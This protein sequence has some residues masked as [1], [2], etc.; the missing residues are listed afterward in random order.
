MKMK[1]TINVILAA[2]LG[3]GMVFPSG[4]DKEQGNVGGE[5]ASS[6]CT[7]HS[8][9]HWDVVTP[10]T[11]TVEGQAK[12]TCGVCYTEQFKSLPLDPEAHTYGEWAITQPNA[13]TDGVAVKTCEGNAEHKYS[14]TLPKTSDERYYN[15]DTLSSTSDGLIAEITKRPSVFE[16]GIRTYT[17][18]S[19][20]GTIAF[21]EEIDA[22]GIV[23]IRDAVEL[24]VGE[25]VRDALYRADGDRGYNYYL[26][27]SNE[28]FDEDGNPLP[29]AQ[30]ASVLNTAKNGSFASAPSTDV[31]SEGKTSDKFTLGTVSAKGS[32]YISGR[33]LQ[34][35]LTQGNTA[36]EAI[37]FQIY[38][39]DD[40]AHKY[41]LFT[42][43]DEEDRVD[44][45]TYEGELSPNAW[46]SITLT[47]TMIDGAR[48][49][50]GSA[51][52]TGNYGVD[53]CIENT[54][55]VAGST[56]EAK[57]FYVDAFQSMLPASNS[58]E[59]YLF[60]DGYTYI[61]DE[62]NNM[63]RWYFFDEEENLYGLKQ[64]MYD[65]AVSEPPII[66]NDLLQGDGSEKFLNGSRL[67]LNWVQGVSTYFGLEALLQG[68]YNLARANVN[69]DYQEEITEIN[70]KK[71]YSFSFGVVE[72]S[73]EN[74]GY[75]SKIA[76]KFTLS[77]LF[78]IETLE[79]T[80]N[81]YVNNTAQED[82]NNILTWDIDETT[83]NAYVVPG[84]EC[85]TRYVSYLKMAQQLKPD[86]GVT[87]TNPH[88]LEEMFIQSFE[89]TYRD[90]ELPALINLALNK[91]SDPDFK[92]GNISPKSAL[93]KYAFDA[94]SYYVRIP[95]EPEDIPIDFE[96]SQWVA[97]CDS[98]TKPG[99]FFL[100]PHISGEFDIV[101]KTTRGI[102]EVIHCSV[103]SNPP[104]LLCPTWF[105]YENGEYKKYTETDSTIVNGNMPI[106]IK[107]VMVGQP[108]YFTA[109]VPEAE[110]WTAASSYLV[111]IRKN[112]VDIYNTE[113]VNKT[114]ENGN[115]YLDYAKPCEYAINTYFMGI[116][117]V[118]YY[119]QE[120]GTHNLILT[121]TESST[122]LCK[123]RVNV[124]AAPSMAE[125]TAKEYEGT[126]RFGSTPVEVAFSDFKELHQIVYQKD[127]VT[128][129][130]LLDE[131]GEK[132]PEYVKA[133]SIRQDQ[134]EEGYLLVDGKRVPVTE[135]LGYEMFVTVTEGGEGGNYEVLKVTNHAKDNT[136]ETE[137]V[138]GQELLYKLGLN[139]AY[140]F[141]LSKTY[142]EFDNMSIDVVLS[143]KVA[144]EGSGGEEAGGAGGT[145]EP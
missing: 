96:S 9:G 120:I 20:E 110:K 34:S 103:K 137:H 74:S 3:I 6:A 50:A 49:S 17:V 132:I 123:M 60:G 10:S 113:M 22:T 100:N 47:K 62:E 145:V 69:G 117:V 39:A 23:N 85:G 56:N 58:E 27:L 12:G 87:D 46:T 97:V 89:V 93:D 67:Y 129:E 128:G 122:I 86:A 44:G 54:Q 65:A 106:T 33:M 32:F 55:F 28:K 14:V 127:A 81:V 64:E 59:H 76:V 83:R 115:T 88:K 35:G 133:T 53:V 135:F 75:F 16:T 126:L 51:Y 130:Y 26:G 90:A 52:N 104:T 119:P 36:A 41:S 118:A 11:C 4:C 29:Y 107:E 99:Y 101:V 13:S 124:V 43:V 1:K 131:N 7:E 91:A 84:Q 31:F 111:R 68:Y 79:M 108:V 78:T 141:V 82:G 72:N 77:D 136:W 125:L 105:E 30:N 92:V 142:P 80:A 2:V 42:S 144:D 109:Q 139:E 116:A 66:Q 38:N 45:A 40:V 114:D 21:E 73:G 5:S 61:S 37:I 138:S 57:T 19:D 102:E 24:A 134:D 15:D 143:E 112:S 94:L 121:S 18:Y 140:N 95:G 63:W 70:G 98:Y 25:E 48:A 71:V 8:V